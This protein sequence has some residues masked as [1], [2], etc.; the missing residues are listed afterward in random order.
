MTDEYTEV[1]A[2]KE[3]RETVGLDDIPDRRRD[4]PNQLVEAFE[5]AAETVGV[6][7]TLDAVY[8]FG[9]YANGDAL[10]GISDLDALFVTEEGFSQSTHDAIE[11]ALKHGCGSKHVPEYYGRLDGFSASS[12]AAYLRVVEGAAVRLV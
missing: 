7:A 6:E 1:A 10:P 8:V 9:S 12:A 5:C 4:L 11:D 3:T 2:L